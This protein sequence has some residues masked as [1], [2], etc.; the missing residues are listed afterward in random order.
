MKADS[1]A[2]ES[3]IEK[4]IDKAQ[5]EQLDLIQ[6]HFIMEVSSGSHYD[7]IVE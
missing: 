4:A 3:E 1:V 6:S 2:Q 5:K 7:V